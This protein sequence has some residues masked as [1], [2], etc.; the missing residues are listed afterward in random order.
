MV[1]RRLKR[2]RVIKLEQPEKRLLNLRRI[3][4]QLLPTQFKSVSNHRIGRAVFGHGIQRVFVVQRLNQRIRFRNQRVCLAL[5]RICAL[6]AL[7]RK[8]IGMTWRT[9]LQHRIPIRFKLLFGQSLHRQMWQK[10]I[11]QHRARKHRAQP[12]IWH[13]PVIAIGHVARHATR[14][15]LGISIRIIQNPVNTCLIRLHHGMIRTAVTNGTCLWLS[16]KCRTKFMTRM[17]GVAPPHAAIGKPRANTVT[18]HTPLFLHRAR[19]RQKTRIRQRGQFRIGM[20]AL[21]KCLN[22]FCMAFATHPRRHL[23]PNRKNRLVILPVT[24]RTP[25]IGSKMSTLAPLFVHAWVNI[26]MAPFARLVTLDAPQKPRM[27]SKP[28]RRLRLQ[29]IKH[30]PGATQ[31]Q[32]ANTDNFHPTLHP[33]C[34][35]VSFVS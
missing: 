3:F 6:E 9:H 14:R 10:V 27:C 17:T 20:P 22:L 32:H 26:P 24:I 35:F 18:P 28:N 31:R 25:H 33:S 30:T 23:P 13:M 2:G 29:H 15:L 21:C 8:T 1:I 12:D 11:L 19:L 4:V 16:R 7:S 5:N 34:P